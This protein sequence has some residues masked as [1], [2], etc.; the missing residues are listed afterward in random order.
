M[1]ILPYIDPTSGQ[2]KYFSRANTQE[3]GVAYVQY[4]GGVV[5]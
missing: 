5:L 2:V 1:P 3:K 4:D